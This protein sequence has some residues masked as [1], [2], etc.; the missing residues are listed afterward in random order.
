MHTTVSQNEAHRADTQWVKTPGRSFYHNGEHYLSEYVNLSTGQAIRKGWRMTGHDWYVFDNTGELITRAHSLIWAKYEASGDNPHRAT[1]VCE[2]GPKDGWWFYADD[3]A[4]LQTATRR[5]ADNPHRP[6]GA[7]SAL[8]Y[9]PTPRTKTNR[10]V[11]G[12]VGQVA[13]YREGELHC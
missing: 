9:F 13:E 4:E 2:G 10:G 7:N 8:S 12:H 6:T 3:F 11:I 1:V 5:M